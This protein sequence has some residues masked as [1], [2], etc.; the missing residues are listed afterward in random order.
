MTES[1]QPPSEGTLLDLFDGAHSESIT[2]ANIASETD[3]SLELPRH[4]LYGLVDRGRLQTVPLA[5]ADR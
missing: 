1:P 5:G 4:N 3:G 2:A